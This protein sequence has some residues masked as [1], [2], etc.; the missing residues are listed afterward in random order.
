[1]ESPTKVVSYYVTKKK[2]YY[3]ILKYSNRHHQEYL[4]SL[5]EQYEQ[6]GH[7]AKEVALKKL[8]AKEKQQHT[9][10]A[11]RLIKDTQH[12]GLTYIL[13][14]DQDQ[15]KEIH[16]QDQIEQM[17]LDHNKHHF[18]QAEGTPFSMTRFGS[19]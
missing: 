17:I 15:W 10:Y 5:A 1:M 9:T 6:Q 14:Q 8:I 16:D 18:N 7:S 4:N 12:T 13:V 3:Q 11:M 19:N 2:Q